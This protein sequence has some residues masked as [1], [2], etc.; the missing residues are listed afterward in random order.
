MRSSS[1]LPSSNSWLPTALKSRPARFIASIVGSSWKKAETSG[2]APIRSPAETT[3]VF[4]LAARA[5][6]M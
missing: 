3:T 4:G 6:A 2:L 1:S 5:A